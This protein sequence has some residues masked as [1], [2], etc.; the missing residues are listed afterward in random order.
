[1]VERAALAASLV[2]TH[3][4]HVQ[5]PHGLRKD[6]RVE[7]R[8]EGSQQLHNQHKHASVWRQL[9]ECVH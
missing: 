3:P 5:Q 9:A 4:P 1:M 6:T 2:W 7:Q 8:P